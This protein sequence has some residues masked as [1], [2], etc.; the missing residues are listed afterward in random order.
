MSFVAKPRSKYRPVVL[1][2]MGHYHKINFKELREEDIFEYDSQ[3]LTLLHHM[4]KDGKWDMV[5]VRFR[6][7]KY[8]K[9]TKDG[10]TI[11]MTAF[12][13][14]CVGWIDRR[15]LTEG[16]L[17]TRNLKGECLASIIIEAGLLK[18]I[19][20]LSITKKLLESPSFSIDI[21]DRADRVI[22]RIAR[23]GQMISVPEKLLSEKLLCIPSAYG[24][25]SYH[26]L[27]EKRQMRS[28]PPHLIT[29]TGLT[30][31]NDFG[32][33]PLAFMAE[34]QPELIP[35]EML[36]KKYFSIVHN[37]D[38]PL[39]AWV[40]GEYWDSVPEHLLTKELIHLGSP[41]CPL[42]YI[43]DH[44]KG[45]VGVYGSA[46]AGSG[47]G[48]IDALVGPQKFNTGLVRKISRILR[49]LDEDKLFRL[50]REARR[51]EKA[52]ILPKDWVDKFG[53]S[54]LIQRELNARVVK[55]ISGQEIILG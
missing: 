20:E 52:M 25:T 42:D 4:A 2:H 44:Y 29:P 1:A 7:K 15:E 32:A 36:N 53:L 16:E 54:S 23:Y 5:P 41:N 31:P 28:L 46:Q 35:K 37:G 26:I 47:K 33:I 43:F 55:D 19:P 21:N 45:E 34:Y 39:C 51:S 24:E 50:Q 12:K 27:A 30:I 18:K 10:D 6:D 38:T 22:H 11:Y 13:A 8:W 9:H 17:L 3:G 40:R 48:V 49:F 14:L